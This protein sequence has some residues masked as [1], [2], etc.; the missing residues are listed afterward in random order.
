MRTGIWEYFEP[1]LSGEHDVQHDRVELALP[2]QMDGAGIVE[3]TGEL[4]I[5][6]EVVPE[7]FHEIGFVVNDGNVRQIHIILSKPFL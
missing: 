4:V 3:E 2:D 7:E 5:V 1:V 6:A